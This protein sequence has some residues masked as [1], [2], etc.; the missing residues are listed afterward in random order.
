MVKVASV[1][2]PVA[3]PEKK[4]ANP[5]TIRAALRKMKLIEPCR[6]KLLRE[7]TATKMLVAEIKIALRISLKYGGLN[8][9][10]KDSPANP[11][12]AINSTIPITIIKPRLGTIF[13]VTV[14]KTPKID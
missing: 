8:S 5:L 10:F 2:L 1:G 6:K 11:K 7:M 9:S 12:I 4:A 14:T 3:N 13:F